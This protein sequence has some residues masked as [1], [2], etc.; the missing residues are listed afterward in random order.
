[1]ESLLIVL[2]VF[3]LITAIAAIHMKRLLSAVIALGALGFGAAVTFL[4]LGAP[5]VAIP[6]VIVDVIALVLLIR[7]TVGR[8]VRTTHEVR[9]TFGIAVSVVLL[10]LLAIFAIS[11][12]S[13][14][15]RFGEAGMST[16][17]KAP[18]HEY[19]EDG[20]TGQL[21]KEVLD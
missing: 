5:D 12:T 20:L 7:A 18:S 9:D 15:P 4:V 16:W 10:A 13:A 6:Q 17:E 3:M 19:L 1:M 11:V 8:D 2:L 21:I 14:L